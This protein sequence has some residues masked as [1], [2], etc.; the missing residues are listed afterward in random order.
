MLRPEFQQ[1]RFCSQMHTSFMCSRNW[2]GIVVLWMFGFLIGALRARAAEVVTQI[3]VCK[4][5][6]YR[7]AG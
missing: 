3:T 5:V 7:T 2:V 1:P 4:D 6:G